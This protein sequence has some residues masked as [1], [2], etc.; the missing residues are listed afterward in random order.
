MY[1]PIVYV[2]KIMKIGWQLTKLL[3]KLAG[4]LFWPTL[5]MT[6]RIALTYYII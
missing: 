1:P 4:L 5:Y 2:S 3:Q 6:G